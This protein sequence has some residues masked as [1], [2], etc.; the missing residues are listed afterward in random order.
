MTYWKTLF[1]I[2]SVLILKKNSKTEF[3]TEL[4]NNKRF[5]TTKIKSYGDEFTDFY[6]K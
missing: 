1:G 6:D 3:N 2:K 4:V 5:L